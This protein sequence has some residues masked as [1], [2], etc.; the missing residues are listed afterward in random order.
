MIVFYV[1]MLKLSPT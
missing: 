1:L